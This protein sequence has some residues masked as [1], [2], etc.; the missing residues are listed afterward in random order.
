LIKNE[1]RRTRSSK[2]KTGGRK[3]N[4]RKKIKGESGK[5]GVRF[6]STTSKGK[7]CADR[8]VNRRGRKEGW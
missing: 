4:R 3:A 8:G 6:V 5:A 1:Q 7:F 2:H